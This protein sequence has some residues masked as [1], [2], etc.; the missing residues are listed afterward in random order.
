MI[1]AT[2]RP[3]ILDKRTATICILSEKINI[4]D[5]WAINVSDV[6]SE[7]N[8]RLIVKAVNNFDSMLDA[9]KSVAQSPRGHLS[10]DVVAKVMEAIENAQGGDQ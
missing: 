9:L 2:Q 3:W 1:Q 6:E 8:A 5:V 10:A 4:A 7:A